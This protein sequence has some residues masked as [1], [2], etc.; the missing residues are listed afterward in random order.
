MFFS[1]IKVGD[2]E[3]KKIISCPTM[4]THVCF[5][6]GNSRITFKKLNQTL[7]LVHAAFTAPSFSNLCIMISPSIL[8]CFLYSSGYCMSLSHIPVTD[9]EYFP[10]L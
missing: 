2:I 8:L 9:L 3:Q 1:Q 7:T 4:V 10:I 5:R 6:W